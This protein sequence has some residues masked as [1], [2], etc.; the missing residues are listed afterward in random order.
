MVTS[1]IGISG[2]VTVPSWLVLVSQLV[3]IFFILT[4]LSP[5]LKLITMLARSIGFPVS[6]ECTCTV[7]RVP[8]P[9]D[10]VRPNRS[11]KAGTSV[12]MALLCDV[13]QQKAA[14]SAGG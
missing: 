3:I 14:R 4:G 1:P 8:D 10:N 12:R 6:A 7:R 9:A 11:R 2:M 13:G 5:C